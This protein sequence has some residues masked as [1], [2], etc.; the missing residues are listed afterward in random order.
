M[1]QKP[2]TAVKL[3]ALLQIAGEPFPSTLPARHESLVR[4]HIELSPFR[5][6]FPFRL[7]KAKEP[8]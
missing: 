1:G 3:Q 2:G 4:L 6:A 8:Y 7:H 5:V